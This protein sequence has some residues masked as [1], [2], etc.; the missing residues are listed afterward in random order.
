MIV[1]RHPRRGVLYSAS[2][3]P[4]YLK[5][6][7]IISS[8]DPHPLNL[9]ESYRFRNIGGRLHVQP[10]RPQTRQRHFCLSPFF[11]YSSALFSAT[12]HSYPH[13]FQMLAD[14]FPCNGGGTPTVL[15]QRPKMNRGMANF[16][17]RN[18]SLR[19]PQPDSTCGNSALGSRFASPP[20]KCLVNYI[21]PNLHEVGTAGHFPNAT[22]RPR[23]CA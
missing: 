18:V 14:S 4:P 15:P 11:S 16:N 9:L 7:R 17:S 10:F 3:L 22:Q 8:A 1:S 21:V 5:S 13:C 2:S 20:G 12:V 23:S 19:C 6:H